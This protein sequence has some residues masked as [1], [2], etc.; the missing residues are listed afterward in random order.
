[1][2]GSAHR[3]I[4][5]LCA[6]A[7][8]CDVGEQWPVLRV[9]FQVAEYPVAFRAAFEFAAR[10]FRI[11]GACEHGQQFIDGINRGVMIAIR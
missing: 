1:M 2:Q 7:F 8:A 4:D 3:V 10:C 9:T 6:L 5:E 11:L